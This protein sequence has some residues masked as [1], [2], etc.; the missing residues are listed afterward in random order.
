MKAVCNAGFDVGFDEC[1]GDSP[2]SG[3]TY[4]L[5]TVSNTTHQAQAEI[6]RLECRCSLTLFGHLRCVISC[7]CFVFGCTVI[8]S[9]TNCVL[10]VTCEPQG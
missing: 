4:A 8:C 7:L 6:N 3:P 9:N 10:D 2:S 5:A 1:W